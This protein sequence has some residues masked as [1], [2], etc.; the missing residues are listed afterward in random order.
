M[1]LMQAIFSKAV[2]ENK[3][4]V[5]IDINKELEKIANNMLYRALENIHD[6][7]GDDTLSDFDCIE[8][9]VCVLEDMDFNG[10]GRHD[11]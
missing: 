3:V 9:I 6:I 8:K 10:G 11:F 2:S 4:Y 5:N 7:L 1:N